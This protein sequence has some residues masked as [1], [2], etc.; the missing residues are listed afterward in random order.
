MNIDQYITLKAAG[1]ANLM[2]IN[3]SY[4]IGWQTA[5]PTGENGPVELQA[6]GRADIAKIRENL[7]RQLAALDAITAEMDALDK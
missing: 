1:R 3:Q 2:K 5:L 6:V 4:A 7:D